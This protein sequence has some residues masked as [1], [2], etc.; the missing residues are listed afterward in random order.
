MRAGKLRSC[1]AGV[2]YCA[3]CLAT[4]AI[5]TTWLA[6]ALLLG[7]QT[8]IASVNELEVPHF[9]LRA[10]ESHL[11]E[12][13]VSFVFGRATFDPSGRILIEKARFKLAS[14]SEPVVTASA[15]YIRLDPWALLGRRFEPREIR[16]TGADL[17]I[18]AMLS[19]SGKP[20][21]LI[22]DLDAGFSIT[23]RGNE[24]SVDYLNCRVGGVSLSAHGTINAGSVARN[25]AEATALPL[26][27]FISR[28]YVTLSRELAH[29]EERMASLDQGS[30]TAVL[31]PSDTR[32]AIINADLFASSLRIAEPPGIEAET[33]RA[34]ARF[35]LLGGASMA[36]ASA[37]AETLRVGARSA[38][39]ARARVRG[40]L[41][42]ET[43]TFVPRQVD[44]A[45]G[46]VSAD[47]I[48]AVSP[49]VRVSPED[50]GRMTAEA[51][52]WLYGS[53]AWIRGSADLRA[54][55]A[56]VDFD[57]WVSP[58]LLEPL[59]R[60]THLKMRTYADIAEPAAVS[61]RLRLGPGWTFTDVAGRIDARRV[62]AYGVK[63]DEVRGDVSFDGR[64]FA[65]RN[66]TAVAG[67]NLALGSYEQDFRT[68]GFRY[69]LRGR[70]RPLEISHWFRGGWWEGIFGRFDFTEAPPD[71]TVDVQGH[72]LH[73]RDFSVFGYADVRKPGILG[74]PMDRVRTLLYIDQAICE[75]FEVEATQAGGIARASFKAS[76]EPVSGS[77][78]GLDLEVDSH[79]DPTGVAKMLPP[80][81]ESAIGAFSFEQPPAIAVRGHFDGPA[82][83]LPHKTLHAEVRSDSGLRVHGVAFS[84]ALFKFDLNDDDIDVTDAE[85]GFAGG[86]ATGKAT[87]AGSGDA[88]RLRF[89]AA[90]THAS[91]G[92]SA[93][94]AEG[95]V[96]RAAAGTST[97]LDTFAREKLDVRLDLAVSA[98]GRPGELDTFVG[99]GNVQIQGT[100]LGGLSLLGGLSRIL[101]VTEL[102]FTQAQAEFRIE[103]GSLYFPELNV[104]G[105]NSAIKAKGSYSIDRRQL[106]FSARIYPFQESRGPLQIFNALSA[107]LSAVFAVKLTGGIDKPSWSVHPMYSALTLP[108][109]SD[110]RQ[111]ES[112]RSPAASPLDNP[113]P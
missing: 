25:G 100:E 83:G 37:T 45:A 4:A 16:A 68:L 95:Y 79:L 26:A 90:L 64:H 49:V 46:S 36:S 6:L 77:W 39:H 21:K 85:A 107:P 59:S 56:D 33:I 13:G 104:I 3:S 111:G 60:R 2:R 92:Q 29:A 11:A 99:D 17:F 73:G 15:I 38:A 75:G 103:N 113:P 24:F 93:A 81:A 12:S 5:W 19:P 76:F 82:A 69:L 42:L 31:T 7:L 70:L 32:G 20:E 43:N 88:R 101:K 110:V 48:E 47:G 54:K 41:N 44:A 67:G 89:K 72:Y 57:A 74:V 91:L 102:R 9:L 96:K 112:D 87:I 28:N 61:G 97:A 58:G 71:A 40:L 86:T 30:L 80:G 66:A 27:E 105:A 50:G 55:S 18:P 8:Y 65:A 53:P 78:K 108:R 52:A 63:L 35:P 106:D 22:E 1:L 98:T 34:S 84:R 62:N 10:I 51:T 109:A 23:S 94:T 14:F